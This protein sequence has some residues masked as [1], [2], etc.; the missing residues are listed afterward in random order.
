MTEKLVMIIKILPMYEKIYK[1][2]IEMFK[3]KA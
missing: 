3:E 2:A 1:E